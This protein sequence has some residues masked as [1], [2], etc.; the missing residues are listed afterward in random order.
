MMGPEIKHSKV[1]M[2]KKRLTELNKAKKRHVACGLDT[3]HID[4]EV[5]MLREEIGTRTR[6]GR[7]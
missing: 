5:V 2:L 7:P 3:V 1:S 4:A 6:E